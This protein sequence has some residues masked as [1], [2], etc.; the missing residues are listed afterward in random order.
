MTNWPGPGDFGWRLEVGLLTN[1]GN[2]DP[3]AISNSDIIV[4]DGYLPPAKAASLRWDSKGGLTNLDDFLLG[5]AD[6][7]MLMVDAVNDSGVM[8]AALISPNF[9]TIS[10]L[11]VPELRIDDEIIRDPRPFKEGPVFPRNRDDLIGLAELKP[12]KIA[13]DVAEIARSEVAEFIT[14]P[15][16]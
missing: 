15:R 6:W 16:S 2:M 1:L 4:G 10:V 13:T 14:Q 8:T 11:L 3:R 12:V 7:R 5:N 9:S